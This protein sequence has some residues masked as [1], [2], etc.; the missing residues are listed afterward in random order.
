MVKR[1]KDG[2]TYYDVTRVLGFRVEDV[3]AG[4]KPHIFFILD[5][6]E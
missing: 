2:D 5:N 6:D 1:L 3:P 4:E